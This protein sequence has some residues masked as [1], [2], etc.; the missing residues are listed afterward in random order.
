MKLGLFENPYYRRPPPETPSMAIGAL[1]R[2]RVTLECGEVTYLRYGSG[3]PLLLVHGIPT[4]SR[5]WEPLLGDLGERFDCIVPDLLGMG[6]SRPEAGADLG[7]PGQAIMLAQLLDALLVDRVL[8]AF[9]DQGGA[10]G[11]QFLRNY[12]E[13]VDA[14]ALCDIVCYDNWV[15]PAIT[16]V[17][18]L[19]RFPRAL[20][21]ATRLGLVDPV[22][23]R[24]WPFPQTT[25]RAPVPPALID[26]WLG[27]MREG[28]ERMQYFCAYVRSQSPCHTADT[29]SVLGGWEKP[30]LVVWAASDRFLSPS[31][32]ARLCAD[33]P[34]APDQPVMLPFAGHFFHAEVPRTAA[35]VLGDFF[36][37]VGLPG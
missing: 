16:V 30:A 29:A 5:L 23:V 6:L 35:A 4:S 14:V 15:V 22:L 20:H 32:A 24:A 25:V 36:A 2:Q 11:L 3:R 34:G 21:I 17:E 8:A 9:H 18:A 27:A 7:S 1:P 33:T 28:G 19:C 13:R 37:G 31:W 10:H 26:D 12:G